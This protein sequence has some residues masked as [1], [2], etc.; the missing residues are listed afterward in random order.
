MGGLG[1]IKGIHCCT[2]MDW[3]L[4]LEL[5][6]DI[7]SFD[8]YNYGEDFLLYRD[9]IKDFVKR[10]GMIAWGIIPNSEDALLRE[11]EEEI[12]RKLESMLSRL[13]IDLEKVIITPSCGLSSLSERGSERVLSLLKKLKEKMG[14]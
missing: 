12:R 9:E 1:G 5:P 11:G 7:I 8:A 6:L 14:G 13:E 3:S 4:L 10:G 2:N